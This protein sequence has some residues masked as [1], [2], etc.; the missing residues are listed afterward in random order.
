MKVKNVIKRFLVAC[1]TLETFYNGGRHVR[2]R[3]DA[4]EFGQSRSTGEIPSCEDQF[5]CF[6]GARASSRITGEIPPVK[7]LF[8]VDSESHAS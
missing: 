7:G 1:Y 5:R 8:Q 3:L 4:F 2:S 6:L